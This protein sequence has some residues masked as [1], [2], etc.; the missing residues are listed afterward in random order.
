MIPSRL[1]FTIKMLNVLIIFKNNFFLTF[2]QSESVRSHSLTRT[3]I[4]YFSSCVTI[5]LKNRGCLLAAF[6]PL[7]FS[8]FS[9]FAI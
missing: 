3:V 7:H 6:I 4:V 8:T 9:K 5:H 1:Q 2:L